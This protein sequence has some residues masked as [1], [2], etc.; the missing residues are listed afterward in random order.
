MANTKQQSRSSMMMLTPLL[1]VLVIIG[2]GGWIWCW[3]NHPIT[4]CD[5][6]NLSLSMGQTDGT[7][8]TLYKH[9]VI[10]NNGSQSCTLSGYPVAM[11]LDSHSM[12]LGSPA[13]PNPLYPI[14]TIT[15]AHGQQA[16]TILGFPEAGNFPNPGTCSAAST[17]LKLVLPGSTQ[18]LTTALVENSCPGFSVT[19][20]KA[21]V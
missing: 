14:T 8:G 9:A 2:F 19:A 18:Y 12:T 16:S 10:T 4:N 11:L 1:I 6:S 20:I 17:T 21:G 13:T 7:A 3:W 15:L 5:A